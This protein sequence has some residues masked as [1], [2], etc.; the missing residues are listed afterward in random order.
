MRPLALRQR[1]E[2]RLDVATTGPLADDARP[3]AVTSG[4]RHVDRAGSEEAASRVGLPIRA[5]HVPW[6]PCRR[7]SEVRAGYPFA[8]ARPHP[9]GDLEAAVGEAFHEP[10]DAFPAVATR[11]KRAPLLPKLLVCLRT[12]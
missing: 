6:K 10:R 1:G 2:E 4:G 7:L 3:H 8:K 9:R 12:D 11:R 5:D